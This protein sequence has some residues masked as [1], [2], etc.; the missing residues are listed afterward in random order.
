MWCEGHTVTGVQVR[1]LAVLSRAKS[2][3]CAGDSEG[4]VTLD[5]V[6]LWVREAKPSG[7]VSPHR[8]T[9]DPAGQRAQS[10]QL[11]G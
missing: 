11:Q 4:S 6:L 9:E 3:V 10:G 8:A 7:T 5:L 2:L 1:R